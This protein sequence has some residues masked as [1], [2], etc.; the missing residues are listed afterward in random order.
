MFSS[1]AI[2]ANNST[3]Y[4]S[5]VLG[6]DSEAQ[7]VCGGIEAQARQALENLKH[8]LEAGGGSLETV[9]K[10]TILLL[11]MNDFRCVNQVYGECWYYGD[12]KIF[13]FKLQYCKNEYSFLM[14]LYFQFLF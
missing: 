7:L 11:D 13:N 10:T 1:Q 9:V 2:L 3:L 8:V 5:G 4:I 14:S 12:I 6:L